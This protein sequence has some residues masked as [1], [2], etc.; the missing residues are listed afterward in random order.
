MQDT[1][2]GRVSIHGIPLDEVVLPVVTLEHSSG[3]HEGPFIF[4]YIIYAVGF[5]VETSNYADGKQ[6]YTGYEH[7]SFWEVDS[8]P[9]PNLGFPEPPVVGI[10]GS[11]DGALQDALR[12]LVNPKWLHPL[13]IWDRILTCPQG[14]Q[15]RLNDSRNIDKALARIAAADMYTTAG[16]IWSYSPYIFE[17][18]DQVFKEIVS[19]LIKLEGNKLQKAIGSM[20]RDDVKSVTIVTR[21][22]HFT[23]AYA[24][25]RFLAYLFH[26]ALNRWWPGRFDILTG[27]VTSFAPTP[28]NKRGAVLDIQMLTGHGAVTRQCELAIIRGGIDKS[29]APTQLLGLTGVDTGRAELGRIPP[30]IRPIG[31]L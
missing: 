11:G 2:N 4:Q 9:H 21:H 13:A 16:A 19:D 18:L 27:E 15:P 8:I 28:G 3:A 12:C 31:M 5:G 6:P 23:K 14:R 7:R 17:S 1:L 24:L 29:T 26:D 10:L 30:A 20:L 22:G 25:N